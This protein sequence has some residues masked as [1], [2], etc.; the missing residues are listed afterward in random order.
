MGNY[1]LNNA[2]IL[3]Y[4]L[5]LQNFFQAYYLKSTQKLINLDKINYF[6]KNL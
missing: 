1:F 6:F 5:F 3:S 4:K 2:L